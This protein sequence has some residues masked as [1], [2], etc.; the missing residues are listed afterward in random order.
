MLCNFS[1][2]GVVAGVCPKFFFHQFCED[3][4]YSGHVIELLD[5]SYTLDKRMF[6]VLSTSL[7]YAENNTTLTSSAVRSFA[8][9]YRIEIDQNLGEISRGFGG[10]EWSKNKIVRTQNVWLPVWLRND[11]TVVSRARPFT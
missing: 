10:K 2:V 4:K 9:L 8:S 3:V 7:E 5:L 6:S 11:C 1:K